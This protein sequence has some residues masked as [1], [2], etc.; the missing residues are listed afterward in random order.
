MDRFRLQL[1][2][3][4]YTLPR[5][6]KIMGKNRSSTI[7]YFEKTDLNENFDV[8]LE[9]GVSLN[10]SPSIQMRTLTELYTQGILTQADKPKIL[11]MLNLGTGENELREDLA[12]YDRA[13]RENQAF[14][15][16]TYAKDKKDGGVKIYIHDDHG[17]HME[18]HT[19]LMKSEEA[20]R[21]DQETWDAMDKH[22]TEH[23]IV[24]AFM[25]Q[26]M[27]PEQAKQA[28]AGQ[29]GG[30]QPGSVPGSTNPVEAGVSAAPGPVPANPNVATVPA[31]GGGQ[32]QPMLQ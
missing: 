3:Q 16:G 32:A 14:V 18:I 30:V 31:P 11:R 13:L 27:N 2:D 15:D 1:M 6:I 26:G 24:L 23:F 28:L 25:Q 5:M 19:D 4:H 10:Q 7:G 29:A 17:L 20:A 9:V 22:I 21:W 12:D 8:R